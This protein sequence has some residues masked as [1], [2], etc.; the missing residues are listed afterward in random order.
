MMNNKLHSFHIPVMG[1]AYTIDTPIKVAQFGIDSVI[2]IVDDELMEKMNAFYCKKFC[3]PYKEITAKM[4]DYRAKR[5]TAYLNTADIIVKKQFGTFCEELSRNLQLLTTFIAM[6]PENAAS[7]KEFQAI[8]PHG[9]AEAIKNVAEKHLRPGAVDVNI[10]TKVD[11][12]NTGKHAASPA[13]FNDA[14]A[15][16]RGFAHSSLNSSLIL[17]AGM[18]P[19]LFSYIATFDDFLPDAGGDLRRRYWWARAS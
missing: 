4:Y 5:I 1:L 15:A 17:S 14:H 10:M 3:L 6:M 11:K 8:F 16:L 12:S 2:S 19:S 18:N 9:S 13:F 7:T